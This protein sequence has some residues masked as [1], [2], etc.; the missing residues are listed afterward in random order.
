MLCPCSI[1][2]VK[3][4]VWLALMTRAEAA[5]N[6]EILALRHEVAVLRLYYL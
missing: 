2:L 1:N 3:V 5:K 4:F 6:A